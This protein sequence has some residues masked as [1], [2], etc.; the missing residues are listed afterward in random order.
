MSQKILA[1]FKRADPI[2]HTYFE[3][4]GFLDIK[5]RA[6]ETFFLDLVESII[7]QQLSVKASDTIFARFK[8]LTKDQITPEKILSIKDKDLRSAGLSFQKIKYI[9]DLSQKVLDKEIVLEDLADKTDREVIDGLTRV[10]GIGRWTAEMFLIFSLG[11]EN[12]FSFGDLGLK[13][14]LKK[15]YRLENPKFEEMEAIVSKWHPYKSYASRILWKSL[16]NL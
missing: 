14:A 3:S 7:S 1:H 4:L 10:K 6:K 5:S 2:L 12:V 15:I 13:N 11:R 8:K 16:N 9:K